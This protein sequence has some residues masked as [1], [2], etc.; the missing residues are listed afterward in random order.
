MG[1]RHGRR[2]AAR[3]TRCCRSF[4][5][6]LLLLPLTST[7]VG[8]PGGSGQPREPG[9][10]NG[11]ER[12]ALFLRGASTNE[13]VSKVLAD[14][15]K[16]K[17]PNSLYLPSRV[18]GGQMQSNAF[19]ESMCAK[20]R[21][22]MYGYVSHTKK[23]PNDLMLGRLFHGQVL[24][25]F[26]F[27]VLNEGPALS[28]SRRLPQLGGRTAFVFLGKYWQSDRY[29][30]QFKNY[31]IDTFGARP[32]KTLDVDH[33]ECVLVCTSHNATQITLKQYL[34]AK[35]SSLTAPHTPVTSANASSV[36]SSVTPPELATSRGTRKDGGVGG[37]GIEPFELKPS[38]PD[39]ALEVVR[40]GL[41]E[42]HRMR[43]A[44]GLRPHSRTP[45]ALKQL[46]R[47]KERKAQAQDKRSLKIMEAAEQKSRSAGGIAADPLLVQER[48]KME[49][50]EK[51]IF[52]AGLSHAADQRKPA[53][54]QRI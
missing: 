35:P 24:D 41:S 18:E 21:T 14:L 37:G 20:T 8:T 38:L 52:F 53:K 40:A 30:C 10:A 12:V 51:K 4:A 47:K 48:A 23:R 25:W 29:L 36:T 17:Q 2:A 9:D 42:E 13:K 31:L 5:L 43:E 16:A 54:R 39:L 19:V 3:M 28:A 1:G 46:Q 15:H 7:A 45:H 11:S 27:R 26:Q 6:A 34:V 32:G 44:L 49:A 22:S 50:A 33:V